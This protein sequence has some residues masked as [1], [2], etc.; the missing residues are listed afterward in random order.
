MD[1]WREGVE[2]LKSHLEG[3]QENK[4]GFFFDFFQV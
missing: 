2:A 4:G 3:R 1:G